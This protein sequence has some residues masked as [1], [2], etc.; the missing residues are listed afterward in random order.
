MPI[1]NKQPINKRFSRSFLLFISSIVG[2]MGY[3]SFLSPLSWMRLVFFLVPIVVLCWSLTGTKKR[4]NFVLFVLILFLLF[5]F[6]SVLM[7]TG[8]TLLSA[9]LSNPPD[10]DYPEFSMDLFNYSM[11]LD[12]I[13]SF[14]TP[15]FFFI[16][17][18]VPGMLIAG[19]IWAI[20]VGRVNEGVKAII[21]VFIAFVMFTLVI[22]AFDL[23]GLQIPGLTQAVKDAMNTYMNMMNDIYRWFTDNDI[24]PDK[25]VGTPGNQLPGDDMPGPDGE[26]GTSDDIKVGDLNKDGVIDPVEEFIYWITHLGTSTGGMSRVGGLNAAIQKS[27]IGFQIYIVSFCPMMISGI[28][29]LF[30]LIFLSKKARMWND[31]FFD[32]FL[33]KEEKIPMHLLHFNYKMGAFVGIII[34]CAWLMFLNFARIYEETG[35]FQFTEIGY[36][37]IYMIMIA[38]PVIF[39]SMPKVAIYTKSNWRNTLKGT[40]FGLG[41]LFL[42]FSFLSGTNRTLDAYSLEHTEFAW[43]Q[44]LNNLIFV[45]PAESMFF[46]VFILS[47]ALGWMYRRGMK[48]TRSLSEAMV[49]DQISK[50]DT[51][52]ETIEL[53]K[54]A[55][56]KGRKEILLFSKQINELKG[57]KT[58]L[59]VNV[60]LR[61]DFMFQDLNSYALTYMII[62]LANFLF[63]V[64]HWIILA[65]TI[66]FFVFWLSGLG[67]IYLVAGCIITFIGWRYGWLSA[68][69]VHSLYNISQILMALM[70][71]GA[72]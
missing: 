37:S 18:G 66:D 63:S 50:I 30:S 67:I 69:L 58:N 44:I 62:I 21:K 65:G 16:F 40:V 15:I 26:T 27:P 52:I 51:Q 24:L 11:T 72:I 54:N 46:H 55:F 9:N 57:E 25:P 32:D 1:E 7:S 34:F 47:F 60:R 8:F 17:I 42:S 68:I 49:Q 38:I 41:I 64:S 43:Q 71:S 56:P 59:G 28:N 10:L 31:E 14:L 3:A 12:A 48:N 35:I 33:P 70:Y 45:A 61:K 20:V 39:L 5:L 36:I 2:L 22:L 53:V 23:I 4:F 29:I 13:D 6:S 19:G